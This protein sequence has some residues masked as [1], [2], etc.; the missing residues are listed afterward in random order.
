[1]CEEDNKMDLDKMVQLTIKKDH[2]KNGKSLNF[3]KRKSAGKVGY[4]GVANGRRSGQ[5]IKVRNRQSP[6]K[7][8][9]MAERKEQSRSNNCQFC[10]DNGGPN[11]LGVD[12]L[13]A[14][15]VGFEVVNQVNVDKR[16]GEILKKFP[17]VVTK[18]IDANKKVPLHRLQLNNHQHQLIAQ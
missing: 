3:V 10:N 5:E 15:G 9:N 6:R 16:I 2:N 12:W 1:M 8:S 4:H 7:A 14:F 11:I 17:D 13:D 18:K